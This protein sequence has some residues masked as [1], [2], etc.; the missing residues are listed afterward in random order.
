MALQLLRSPDPAHLRSVAI[1]QRAIVRAKTFKTAEVDVIESLREVEDDKTFRLFE[2]TSVY[3]Y[4]TKMMGLSEDVACTLISIMR[5]SRKVPE[6]AAAIRTGAITTSKARKIV[7]VITESNKE[8]WLELAATQTSREIEKAVVAE[9]PKLATKESIRYKTP[10]RL[11][12]VLGISEEW[13]ATLK[14]VKDLCSQEEERAV[15]TEE[16]LL[17]V[18]KS[19]IER[20]DPIAKAE[21]SQKRAAET[22]LPKTSSVLGRIKTG[23][24]KIPSKIL[25]EVH[26]RDGGRCTH[27]R[28]DGTRCEARRWVDIHHV[29][30]VSSGGADEPSNLVTLCREHHAQIHR[31]AHEA[32][33]HC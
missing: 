10:D 18:M 17:I 22:S 30:P 5:K 6:L 8:T 15:S 14:R 3:A 12:L 1:H 31:H 21:R 25:H 4:A 20:R 33:A 11:E 28:Q 29:K 7:S 24:R 27:Q 16:A 2:L 26:L 13:V 19:F 32:Q 23:R 9:C